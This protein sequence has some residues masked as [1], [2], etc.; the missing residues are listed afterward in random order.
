MNICWV[1]K[2]NKQKSRNY[3]L[4]TLQYFSAMKVFWVFLIR[5][6]KELKP[7]KGL[8]NQTSAALLLLGLQMLYWLS[9]LFQLQEC[10]PSTV[11]SLLPSLIPHGSFSNLYVLP[12]I[13]WGNTLH[14]CWLDL[15]NFIPCSLLS[16]LYYPNIFEYLSNNIQIVKLWTTC[17]TSFNLIFFNF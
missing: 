3:N 2:W 4:L 1:G 6:P 10:N 8:G 13:H 17:W 16:V 15:I 9:S 12:G 5:V 7:G 11:L 14:F